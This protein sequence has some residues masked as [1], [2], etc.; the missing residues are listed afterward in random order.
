MLGAP[1]KNLITA[2]TQQADIF[3]DQTSS[4]PLSMA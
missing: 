2:Q 4:M 3:S 1:K